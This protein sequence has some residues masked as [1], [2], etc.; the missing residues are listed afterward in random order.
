M[1]DVCLSSA[2]DSW[3][4]TKKI[5]LNIF[6][7]SLAAVLFIETAAILLFS[8]IKVLSLMGTGVVRLFEIVLII[9]LV[10]VWGQGLSS[11]GL[12]PST[13]V[14]G[15]IRGLFWSAS[16]GIITF[17]AFIFLFLLDIN[18]FALIHTRL[19]EKFEEMILFFLVG[20]MIGPVAEEIFFRGIIYGFF[21][22]WGVLAALILSSTIFVLAHLTSGIPVTQIV[23]GIIFAIAYEKEGSLVVPITI[24]SLGNMAI[25]ALSL[26]Y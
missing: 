25:F 15:L 6:F 24:H 5:E 8:E 13:M 22:R 18:P 3:T 7:L 16:F 19:P 1:S 4:E 17:I 9:I 10:L 21:R 20:G 14:K 12:A 26:I 2:K 23:G 11:I